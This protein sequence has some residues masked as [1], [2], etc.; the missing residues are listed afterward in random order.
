MRSGHSD[1]ANFL[2]DKG[3]NCSKRDLFQENALH[4]ICRIDSSD[5]PSLIKRLTEAGCNIDAISCKDPADVTDDEESETWD[6]NI[7]DSDSDRC[8]SDDNG[9]DDVKEFSVHQYEQ[10]VR[11]LTSPGT[12]LHRAVVENNREAVISLCQ[13]GCDTTVK[14]ST[15]SFPLT[16]FEVAVALHQPE[17]MSAILPFYPKTEPQDWLQALILAISPIGISQG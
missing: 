6:F 15:A 1:I 3:A 9:N 8:S 11:K 5:I 16:P 12:P 2:I 7:L 13:F 4:W 14:N 10:L 17:I